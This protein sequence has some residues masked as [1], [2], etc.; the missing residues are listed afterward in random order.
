MPS[1]YVR[2]DCHSPVKRPT[3]ATAVPSGAPLMTAMVV[4]AAN[5]VLMFFMALLQVPREWRCQSP[6]RDIN[7]AHGPDC[8]D[9]AGGHQ[10]VALSRLGDILA[11]VERLP[12]HGHLP[13]GVG[14]V[15]PRVAEDV[16]KWRSR[17]Q[18]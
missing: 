12:R 9:G 3:S 15:V 14:C 2:F 4:A 17:H 1:S 11:D 13:R 6:A 7:C 16:H 10:I 8:I 18:A 5:S